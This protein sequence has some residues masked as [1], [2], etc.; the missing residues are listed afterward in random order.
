[1]TTGKTIDRVNFL[2]KINT[3][4]EKG[5]SVGEVVKIGAANTS[6]A[7]QNINNAFKN[8]ELNMS[9]IA[10]I[11]N[12]TKNEINNAIIKFRNNTPLFKIIKDVNRK[13]AINYFI[14][15]HINDSDKYFRKIFNNRLNKKYKKAP[16]AKPVIKVEPKPKPEPTPEPIKELWDFSD[17]NIVETKR[18]ALVQFHGKPSGLNYG[19]AA[20]MC[21]EG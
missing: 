5:M 6:N 4:K 11:D 17:E 15:L 8:I 18:P 13:L 14:Y 16:K 10:I 2:K 19:C 7:W 12:L 9:E 20:N 21:A 3:Y 1:M